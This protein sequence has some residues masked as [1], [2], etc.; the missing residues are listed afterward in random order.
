MG[1]LPG[2]EKRVTGSLEERGFKQ[3][4]TVDEVIRQHVRRRVRALHFR[5]LD[6]R[7]D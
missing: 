5:V 3:P 6:D 1:N 7:C 2:S 4:Q